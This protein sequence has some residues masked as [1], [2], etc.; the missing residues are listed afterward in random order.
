MKRKKKEAFLF[1]TEFSF[2]NG[3]LKRKTSFD[4]PGTHTGLS[5]FLCVESCDQC[6]HTS[7]CP[8]EP[9]AATF[10]VKNLLLL[11]VA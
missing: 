9:V 7:L 1:L 5:I 11:L 10:S 6:Q 8:K 2:I 3:Y 4:F